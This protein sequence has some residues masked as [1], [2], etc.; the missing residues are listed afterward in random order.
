MGWS[1]LWIVFVACLVAC[2]VGFKKFVWFMS[3]GYG[4][5]VAAGG[6]AIACI[7]FGKMAWVNWLQMLVFLL[8]GG[9][10]AWFLWNR[11]RS[12]A[13]YAKAMQGVS[14]KTVPMPVM[15]V[16]WLFMGALY[17]MQ[18]SPLFYRLYNGSTDVVVPLIGALISLCGALIEAEADRQKSVW[19]KDHPNEVATQGMFKLSRC[20]NYF[21]ELTMWLGVFVGGLTT[22]KG[23]GQWCFAIVAL[24][25]IIII[26][27]DGAKRLETRQAKR[28]GDDA[29]YKA[30]CAK[31]PIILPFI[32]IYSLGGKKKEG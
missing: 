7:F 13:S 21:G 31:T 23:F 5:G 19:K 30:Y 2:S 20:P 14:D 18:V 16:M 15:V 29:A 24:I 27:F 32:P 10:L 28:Y 12:S 25:A 1:L 8:Y 9:R 26:M 11:E 17:T 6:L 22:Y 3:I 4:L